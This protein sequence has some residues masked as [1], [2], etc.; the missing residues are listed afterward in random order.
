[1]VISLTPRLRDYRDRGSVASGAGG[2]V[3]DNIDVYYGPIQAL[4]GLSLRVEPGEMV[5]LL[6]ANGAGKSTTLRAIS[7]L[8]APRSGT[9]EFDGQ[10]INGLEAHDVVARGIS[11]VP[12]G[13]DL[14]PTMSVRDNLR[15][16]YWTRRSDR[17]GLHESLARVMGY[18]PRLEERADQAAG[19]LSGGEQQMLVV[20]RALMSNPRMLVIDELSFGLAPKIVEQLFEILRV[21]NQ[22]G[23]SILLVEQF[24]HM[25]LQHTHRAYVLAKGEIQAE[26]SSAR[27]A[28]D[29]AVLSAYLGKGEEAPA[30]RRTPRRRR[31]A[32]PRPRPRS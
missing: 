7:G 14:F 20:A 32:S 13:R 30:P 8:V 17:S 1:M 25:A 11:H 6:G 15:A 18:F 26:G 12:E 27:L 22:G 2:L 21:V 10:A 31:T 5:A 3:I 4:R 16:G 23:T 28:D 29:P 24:V 19:T 9:I